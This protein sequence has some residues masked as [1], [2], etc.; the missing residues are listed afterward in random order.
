MKC[1]ALDFG[2]SALKYCLVDENAQMYH[3]GKM[4]APL[5]SREQFIGT[6]SSLYEQFK[7]E[8]D[9]ITISLPGYIDSRTGF[10][11]GSGAY[12]A[13]YG[14]YIPELLKEKCPVNIA[15]ENDGKC[16]ALSESWAGALRNTND[17]VVIILGTGVAGGLIKDKTIH[18]GKGF[19]AGELS[20]LIMTPG[21]YNFSAMAM[22][23]CCMAGIAYK[24]CKYKNLNLDIQDASALL[25]LFDQSFGDQYPKY[26]DEP[27]NIKVTGIQFEKWLD[28]EDYDTQRVYREFIEALAAM[29]FNIQIIYAPEKVVIGGGLSR[30][31]RVI[32]DL[33]ATLKKY[34]DTLGISS[35]LQAEI[36]KSK[37]LQECNLLGAMFHYL[38]KFHPQQIRKDSLE[39]N[40]K[41]TIL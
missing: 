33:R 19:T 6:V 18:T 32:P 9:G 10:L 12:Q 2:G 11:A 29:V 21:V 36:V 25:K 5:E 39:R 27:Q 16:G 37:Y 34:Y 14:C 7:S 31:D 41:T 38:Q 26:D 30:I 1:L 40:Y 22:R 13:L 20:F 8:V 4:D 15:V 28:D 17:G 3:I 24:I 35:A 23:D